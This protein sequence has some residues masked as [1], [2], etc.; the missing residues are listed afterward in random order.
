MTDE[1]PRHSN[2]QASS[3][4][5]PPPSA[6]RPASGPPL[7]Y[8][9]PRPL[10]AETHGGKALKKP[11]AYGFAASTYAVVLHAQEF[12]FAAATY[13]IVFAD[14]DSAMPLAVLGYRAGQNLF[15]DEAGNWAAGSYIPSYV[16]RY[17]FASGQGVTENE[18]ILYLDEGSDLIVDRDSDP[19][20]EPLFEGGEPSQRTKDMLSLCAAFQQQTTITNAFIEAVKAQGL[21]ELKE[22]RL[23]LP[24]GQS[25]QL[26]G[27]RIIE[28]ERFN[29]LPDEV[30][31]DW[32]RNGW[33]PLVY[34]HWAS[35]DNF[36]RL[37][38]R[39]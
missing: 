22:I 25:Q 15:V 30:Y 10:R 2:Q 36:L 33:L 8:K 24:G 27:L 5:A 1:T 14:D 19:E 26:A 4:E 28:E 12:R 29:A 6:G 21:L 17:P 32:R 35:M 13:P 18:P 34:W 7:F 37:V 31:L 11:I 38:Q 16:R 3:T 23:D 9:E 39:G 20:A